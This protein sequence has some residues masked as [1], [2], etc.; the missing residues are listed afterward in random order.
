MAI[1]EMASKRQLAYVPALLIIFLFFLQFGWNVGV[2]A[3]PGSFIMDYMVTMG[4][5]AMQGRAAR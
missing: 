5:E 3:E 1:V 4:M 2:M